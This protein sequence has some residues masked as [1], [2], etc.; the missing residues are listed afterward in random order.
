MASPVEASQAIPAERRG[1][2]AALAQLS[3]VSS[4][5]SLAHDISCQKQ[6]HR[7]SEQ[8]GLAAHMPSVVSMEGMESSKPSLCAQ[9]SLETRH[10]PFQ[11]SQTS[12]GTSYSTRSL[13]LRTT[14]AT[15]TA[16]LRGAF[17]FTEAS[18]ECE[19]SSPPVSVRRAQP[20]WQNS[21]EAAVDK[22]TLQVMRP[23]PS[24]AVCAATC[25]QHKSREGRLTKS[26][27]PKVVLRCEADMEDKTAK[28]FRVQSAPHGHADGDEVLAV[29]RAGPFRQSADRPT[30][31]LRQR[32]SIGG[33]SSPTAPIGVVWTARST[34]SQL[35]RFLC[36][37]ASADS[38]VAKSSIHAMQSRLSFSDCRSH[39]GLRIN[40]LSQELLP[41]LLEELRRNSPW[42]TRVRQLEEFAA[43][44]G[45]LP[46]LHADKQERLLYFWL[47]NTGCEI[48]RGGMAAMQRH[49]RLLA[50]SVLL[51][52]N[53]AL[54]WQNPDTHF[55]RQCARLRDYM[56][57]FNML[58]K[59]TAMRTDES[60]R[61]AS[62]LKTQRTNVHSHAYSK[63]TREVRMEILSALHPLVE[64]YISAPVA[65]RAK[66]SIWK[67][68]LDLQRF[69]RQAG[70]LPG[71]QSS[72]KEERSLYY[73]MA[74]Q[75][76]RL[77]ELS[78]EQRSQL[79]DLH[80]LVADFC[81]GT[82][83]SCN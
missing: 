73:W 32:T 25:S 12:R 67:R 5:R 82:L 16:K 72:C 17:S 48:K 13:G 37:L 22:Q 60:S 39:D 27:V 62:F 33:K 69:V 23:V 9:V 46:N 3:C 35:A 64:Q 1:G 59:K 61:L 31:M 49:N 24:C 51:L 8:S 54:K 38:R 78:A 63:S 70:C 58:P 29:S 26:L 77:L 52:R 41:Q 65:R 47:K 81:R 19:S 42:E 34:A 71:H 53:R 83:Q 75:K 30:Q 44:H 10:Q 40:V 6:H 15:G 11:Q 68:C 50:S 55:Q 56:S 80:P 79:F 74:R 57:K 2:S 14:S 18:K 66:P 7:L 36:V 43:R 21:P 28:G 4:G 76:R 20:S 45:R